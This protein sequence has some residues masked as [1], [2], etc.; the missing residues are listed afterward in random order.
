MPLEYM[1]WTYI[2]MIM[3]G[4]RQKLACNVLWVRLQKVSNVA[5]ACSLYA[6]V[7]AGVRH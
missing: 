3:F 7:A 4:Q 5:T 6:E 2:K 1:S